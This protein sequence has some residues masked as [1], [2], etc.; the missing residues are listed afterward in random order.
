[1]Q[2]PLTAWKPS[3]INI[4]HLGS[5][6]F[7]NIHAPTCTHTNYTQLHTSW[8]P[9]NDT[10]RDLTCANRRPQCISV[11][12][13]I[14]ISLREKLCGS[15]DSLRESGFE[16]TR[17][18]H[19]SMH[20]DRPCE[21]NNREAQNRPIKLICHTFPSVSLLSQLKWRQTLQDQKIILRDMRIFPHGSLLILVIITA[22]NY[23]TQSTFWQL[24]LVKL[25]TEKGFFKCNK[26]TV[27]NFYHC[28]KQ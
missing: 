1:M 26:K 20:I 21:R 4:V 14:I 18:V 10:E 24:S 2:C 15:H 9:F 12:E 27:T 19:A 17:V 3:K 28:L 6:A 13:Q 22:I 11:T 25:H 16:C 7:T 8:W 5:M 23:I